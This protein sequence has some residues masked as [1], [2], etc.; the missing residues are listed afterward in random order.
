M[1]FTKHELVIINNALNE[2]LELLDS[3]DYTTRIGGTEKE[4]NDLLQKVSNIV[5]DME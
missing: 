1:E 2:A 5:K 4:I 3:I